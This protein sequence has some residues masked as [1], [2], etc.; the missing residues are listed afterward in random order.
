MLQD[1]VTALDLHASIGRCAQDTDD[2]RMASWQTRQRARTSGQKGTSEKQARG[3]ER[4][5]DN[6]CRQIGMILR[7]PTGYQRPYI[8]APLPVRLRILV[9]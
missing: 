6:A 3:A 9:C 7:M 5:W 1:A 2:V 4:L 8:T